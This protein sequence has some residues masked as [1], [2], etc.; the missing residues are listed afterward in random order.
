MG[1]YGRKPYGAAAAVSAVLTSNELSMQAQRNRPDQTSS[2]VWT[3]DNRFK[4]QWTNCASHRADTSLILLSLWAGPH[5]WF[6]Y[7][8]TH[9]TVQDLM[10]SA[11]ST[12]A[13]QSH[14][15]WQYPPQKTNLNGWTVLMTITV[16]I[17]FMKALYKHTLPLS[18]QMW[19]VAG[20]QHR[21]NGIQPPVK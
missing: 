19:L 5:T 8:D 16:H 17:K 2:T 1:K 10:V 21:E 7:Q 15:D 9:V 4:C 11:I 6:S 3:T 18:E 20:I 14:I 12:S 13:N